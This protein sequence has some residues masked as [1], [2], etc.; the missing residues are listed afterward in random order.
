M[1][2]SATGGAKTTD[3][4][5]I[6]H[7]F[8]ADGTLSCTDG[9][10]TAEVLIIGGGG[11]GSSGGGGAASFKQKLTTITGAMAVTVGAA[12]TG[13][14]PTTAN[15]GAGGSSTFDG[16][17]ATGGGG[18]GKNSANGSAGASGGGGGEGAAYTGGVGS[19]GY[20]GGNA[21]T[22]G[23]YP[24]G[25][26][27]GCRGLGGTAV[28]STP[29]AGGTGKT[30]DIILRGTPVGYCG[31][32]GGGANGGTTDFANG[33]SGG[34]DG[35]AGGNGE[36]ASTAGGGGGGSS[37]ANTGGGGSVGMVV[38]RYLD[39]AW[40]DDGTFVAWGGDKTEDNGEYVHRF[41]ESG[42]LE[43]VGTPTLVEDLVVGGGGGGSSGGG[44]A[45]GYLTGSET[46]AGTMAVTVGAGGAGKDWNTAVG[47]T[48]QD[49]VFGSR[50]A[51]GG[52]GG[53]KNGGAGAAGGSGGGAGIISGTGGAASPAGQG[54]AGR[55]VKE[56]PVADWVVTRRVPIRQDQ[57]GER[58][59]L[60]LLQRTRPTAGMG[61]RVTTTTSFSGVRMSV[62]Q[63]VG[64]EATTRQA[65]PAARPHT[66][67]GRGRCTTEP[68]IL[69]RPT[70]G[71]AEAGRGR[72]PER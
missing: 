66:E 11:G 58:R 38:V 45:G 2:F 64:A 51:K 5:H 56:T 63:A 60:A 36:S 19:D 33:T 39:P 24:A 43:C 71:A 17:T 62:T 48:G 23:N 26:G 30:S 67:A 14:V 65:I 41:T 37:G 1:A 25:G 59:R 9:P 35:H 55:P 4:A 22:G 61:A 8:T 18:G 12:G 50:T 15:G 70:P 68:S 3:R 28:G 27:G 69:V 31:G 34:G 72:P 53:G 57:E 42:F 52:G 13:A 6:V 20:N 44:G 32:G 49:S 29:G 54:N 7:V 10:I 16:T 21:V 40:V 46:L 47:D